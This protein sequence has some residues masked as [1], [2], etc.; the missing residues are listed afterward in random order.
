MKDQCQTG[1]LNTIFGST[2]LWCYF[3]FYIPVFTFNLCVCV[4][5]CIGALLYLVFLLNTMFSTVVL[6]LA[7]AEERSVSLSCFITYTACA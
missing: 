7:S 3:E 1:K 5:M 2:I 6:N 4:C